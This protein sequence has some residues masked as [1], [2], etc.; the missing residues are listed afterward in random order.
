V[1]S[2]WDEVCIM[3]WN[4]HTWSVGQG[5]WCARGEGNEWR[6]KDERSVWRRSSLL[7][8]LLHTYSMYGLMMMMGL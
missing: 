1:T 5:T 3:H 8:L 7:L 6:G 2:L 4:L